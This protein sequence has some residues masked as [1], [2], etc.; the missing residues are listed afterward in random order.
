VY[1]D[2]V[3]HIDIRFQDD[4]LS[5]DPLRITAPGTVRVDE[6]T[7]G[8]AQT[9]EIIDSHGVAT[10]LRFRAAPTADML[11]SVAPGAFST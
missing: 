3:V 8:I 11:D 9:L 5:R 2:L 1:N 4:D 10:R 6:T 7:Q